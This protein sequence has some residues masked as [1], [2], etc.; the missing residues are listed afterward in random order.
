[1]N[2]DTWSRLLQLLEDSAER[3]RQLEEQA[4]NNLY[5]HRDNANYRR[6]QREKTDLLILLPESAES[7][8][9]SLAPELRT[10]VTEGL[11]EFAY[12]ARTARS[13]DS[14]FYMSVLLFPESDDE[15]ISPNAFDLFVETVGRAAGK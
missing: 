4:R 10:L 5:L 2:N 15:Q 9:S 8:L 6:L 3:L 7:L 11:E 12:E 13:L 14:I 1:M